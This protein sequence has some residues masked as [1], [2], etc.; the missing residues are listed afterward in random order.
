MLLYVARAVAYSDIYVTTPPRGLFNNSGTLMGFKS[1]KHTYGFLTS[2]ISSI[3]FKDVNK[4]IL[5]HGFL[6][7]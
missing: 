2:L 7:I 5:F 3:E 6:D 1:S 4:D